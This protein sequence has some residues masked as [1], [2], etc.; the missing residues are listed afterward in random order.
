MKTLS[1][2]Y[3]T[4]TGI[5]EDV[6]IETEWEQQRA[7]ATGISTS[8]APFVEDADMDTVASIARHLEAVA[9]LME[10]HLIAGL[11]NSALEE[12]CT[13]QG[14]SYEVTYPTRSL[15]GAIVGWAVRSV[16]QA[17]RH[18][19]SCWW[20]LKRSQN[21]MNRDHG[22]DDA[23]VMK[24]ARALDFAKTQY[25]LLQ[26][27][28]HRIK[29]SFRKTTGAEWVP[30]AKPVVNPASSYAATEAREALDSAAKTFGI[31]TQKAS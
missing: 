22:H 17:E 29:E 12:I 15:Y 1:K 30:Y 19:K 24:A 25:S 13:F 8:L 11:D 14:T 28:E 23:E 4:D 18:G 26:E 7:M 27:M 6:S 5:F 16:A 21:E 9:M 31:V 10:E 2:E 3:G 20:N